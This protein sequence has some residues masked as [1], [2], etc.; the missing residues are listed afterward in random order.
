MYIIFHM[1]PFLSFI[2]LDFAMAFI[3]FCAHALDF[4]FRSFFSW[5]GA[6][7]LFLAGAPVTHTGYLRICR[8]RRSTLA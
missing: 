2:S 7:T 3:Q 8:S 1:F 5:L 4:T 6:L